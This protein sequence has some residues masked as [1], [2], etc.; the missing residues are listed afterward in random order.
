MIQEAPTLRL[1]KVFNSLRHEYVRLRGWEHGG[2]EWN[3]RL[4]VIDS[5]HQQALSMERGGMQTKTI[6]DFLQQGLRDEGIAST[7]TETFSHP[8]ANLE[9]HE[10]PQ[11]V[12]AAMPGGDNE[13]HLNHGWIA[14]T[15]GDARA[16][17][18]PTLRINY[19]KRF[20]NLEASS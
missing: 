16:A 4:E 15:A 20:H 6:F 7:I 8:L 18:N 5:L 9:K 14:Y 13:T 3:R 19:E 10:F 11:A 2:I 12:L 1:T 17:D